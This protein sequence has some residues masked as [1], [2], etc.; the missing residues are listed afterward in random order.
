MKGRINRQNL[1]ALEATPASKPKKWLWDTEIPCYGAYRN[2]DGQ[3]SFVYQ[4]RMPGEREIRSKLLGR[5]GEITVEQA[6]SLAAEMAFQRRQG[7]DPVKEAQRRAAEEKGKTDLILSNYAAAYL[8][9]RIVA[10]NPLN[11]AQTKIVERDI[12][13]NLGDKRLDTMTVEDVEEFGKLMGERAPSARRTGIV[14]LKAILNDAVSRGKILVSPANAVETPVAGKRVR[15][16]SEKE[17][18]RFY[19]AIRDIGDS[20]SDTL[21]TIL[22]TGKRKEEVAEMVWEEL[23]LPK[24]VWMLPPDRNKPKEAF[25]V[26][27]PRQVVE[28][29]KRQQPDPKKRHGPVFTLNGRTSSELGS[30]VKDMIDANMHRRIEL[31]EGSYGPADRV[32]HYTIHDLRKVMTSTLQERPFLI[33]KDLLDVILLHKGEAKVI[34]TYALSKL[35][36]EAGE[37]LQKWNDWLDDLISG[38][39]MFAGGTS[40]PRMAE[41]EVQRRILEFRQ[42]WPERADQKAARKRR[43][44]NAKIGGAPRGRKARAEARKREKMNALRRE[45]SGN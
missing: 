18:K 33:T 11:K 12:V 29:I 9:R 37:A 6:R 16:L 44:E 26:E 19:E 40:L 25:L 17:V 3:I 35:E 1:R 13:G 45:A 30:Q 39:D 15:R 43:E 8:E 7:I 14:Y 36:I 23:D 27:L 21:E 42:G 20:R 10:G 28:I 38:D 4:Y 22:R 32:A 31:A 34:D 2:S 24:A 41:S 5:G